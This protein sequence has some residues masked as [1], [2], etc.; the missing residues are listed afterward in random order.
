MFLPPKDQ[1]KAATLIVHPDGVAGLVAADGS[2][3]DLVKQAVAQGHAVLVIDP[4]RVGDKINPFFMSAPSAISHFTCY[5]RS[6]AAERVQDIVDALDVLKG[7][8]EK[9]PVN[10][11]GIGWAGP[12]CLLAR[13]QAPFVGGTVIDANQFEYRADSDLDS[14]QVLPGIVRLGGLRSVS[15]LAAP[16]KLVIHNTGSDLDTSWIEEAYR[17]EGAADKLAVQRN[18]L[19][20]DQVISALRN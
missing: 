13:T 4:Y 7:H 14:D 11:V 10:L 16:G 8:A 6:T 3:G 5:N 18:S 17:L 1:W 9:R 2:P 20:D 19:G 15:C 12:L